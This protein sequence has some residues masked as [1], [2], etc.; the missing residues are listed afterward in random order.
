MLIFFL[1][2]YKGMR[3]SEVVSWYLEQI[4]DCIETEEELIEKKE[5]VEKVI[6]RLMYKVFYSNSIRK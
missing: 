5:K 3:K 2:E 4:Q 1:E 6:D